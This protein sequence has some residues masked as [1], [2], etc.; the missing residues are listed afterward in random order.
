MYLCKILVGLVEE[1]SEKTGIELDRVRQ[2]LL[3]ETLCNKMEAYCITKCFC[4]DYEIE[5]VFSV[6][7]EK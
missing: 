3:R 5:D 7:E 1:I 2:I 4:E 6:E